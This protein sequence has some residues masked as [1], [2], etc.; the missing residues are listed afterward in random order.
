MTA[1]EIRLAGWYHSVLTI[2]PE[3]QPIHAG[4][5]I[6]FLCIT[7]VPPRTYKIFIRI[8]RGKS[9]EDLEV[10]HQNTATLHKWV[11]LYKNILDKFKRKGQCVTMDSVYMGGI[12]ALI[13]HHEWKSNMV[14]TSQENR[15]RTDTAD[16]KKGMKKHIYEAIMW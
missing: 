16:E 9:N 3:P 14:G 10:K 12:M 1:G 2:G 5:T 8:Y 4:L 13:G 7:R 6:H 11:N 15:T